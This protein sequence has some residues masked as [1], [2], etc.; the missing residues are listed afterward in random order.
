M[1]QPVTYNRYVQGIALGQTTNGP[2]TVYKV[3]KPL[4]MEEVMGYTNFA[5]VMTRATYTEECEEGAKGWDKL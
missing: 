3:R 5:E 1:I 4:P 2:I